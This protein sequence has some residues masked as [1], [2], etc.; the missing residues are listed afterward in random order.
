MRASWAV[1]AFAIALMALLLVT[2]HNAWDL[3]TFLAPR[4]EKPESAARDAAEH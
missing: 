1:S 3:V 2:I 4:A